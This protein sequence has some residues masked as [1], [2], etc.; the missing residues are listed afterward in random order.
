MIRHVLAGALA[1]ILIPSGLG[2]QTTLTIEAASV[3][4]HESATV[5]APDH[6]AGASR[7]RA[8]RDARGWG[9]GRWSCGPRPR[10]A[11]VMC[12]SRL[13]RLSAPTGMV[14]FR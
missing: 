11:S 3:D 1:I 9:I 4:V 8:A 13:D 6:R 2:A 14:S 12:G 10:L 5:A 7:T